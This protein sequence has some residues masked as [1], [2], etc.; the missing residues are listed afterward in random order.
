MTDS[1][2]AFVDTIVAQV[3]ALGP[4]NWTKGGNQLADPI[5]VV[6]T[7]LP[8]NELA[9]ELSSV[10]GSEVVA[11]FFGPKRP[12]GPPLE[13]DI[14]MYLIKSL[15]TC[16]IPIA[17]QKF[18]IDR[19]ALLSRISQFVA[20]TKDGKVD[21]TIF[22]RLSNVD[23]SEEFEFIEGIRFR[24]ISEQEVRSRYP[25]ERYYAALPGISEPNW[26]KHRV[27]V[28]VSKRG[29][30]AEME[31]C[32][33]YDENESLI[34]SIIHPFILS[35]ICDHGWPHVTHV[36]YQSQLENS[37]HLH[38]TGGISSKPPLLTSDN[39]D[40]LRAAYS[41]LE[42]AQNDSILEAAL[43]RFMIAKKRS[44]NHVN[45]SNEANWDKVV[46]YV[47]AMES[48][49]L[50]VNGNPMPQELSY[51]FRLNGSSLL[52]AAIGADRHQAFQSLKFLYELRSKVVHGSGSSASAAAGKFLDAARIDWSERKHGLGQIGLICKLVEG[53]LRSIFFYLDEI[54]DAERPYRKPH[55][56]EE[57]LW[58]FENSSET[59][60]SQTG[61]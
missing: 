49:F 50:T 24:K 12:D 52:H 27:E 5:H 22:L 39:I 13:M 54:T 29:T 35:G 6:C 40:E 19:E 31:G 57:M 4:E 33:K 32:Q 23:I 25:V 48:L 11:K 30:P 36:L 21:L 42:N 16:C 10:V 7:N 43:D 34:Q 46:D 58:N 8:L 15:Q 26:I 1:V 9:D 55:G 45:R 61:K 51:R 56:W 18:K 3:E 17:G 60:C 44:N 47:I 41:L 37:C 20:I 2:E 53:W 28:V 38:S 14:V 59:G